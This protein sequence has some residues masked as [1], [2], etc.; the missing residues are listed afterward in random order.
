MTGQVPI[1]TV[2]NPFHEHQLR[3]HPTEKYEQ[4]NK[5]DQLNKMKTIT[6]LNHAKAQIKNTMSDLQELM[7][8]HLSKQDLIPLV[9]LNFFA[10]HQIRTLLTRDVPFPSQ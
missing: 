5:G 6:Y 1:Q 4:R 8:E 3:M 2:Q 7:P 9:N 10:S